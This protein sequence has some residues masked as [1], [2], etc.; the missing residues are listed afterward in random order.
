MSYSDLDGLE[1]MSL[2]DARIDKGKLYFNLSDGTCVKLEPEGDCCASCYIQHI[3][4]TD[5]LKGKGNGWF[6]KIASVET[7]ESNPSAEEKAEEHEALD[8]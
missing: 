5:A 4:G 2:V 8:C 7:I 3:S 1:G 6:A